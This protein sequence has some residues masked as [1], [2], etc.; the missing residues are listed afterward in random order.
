[1]KKIEK[2]AIHLV[3]K[4][5]EF[6]FTVRKLEELKNNVMEKNR[7]RQEFETVLDKR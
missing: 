1:M 6:F 5:G 4:H 2:R 7:Y 3:S